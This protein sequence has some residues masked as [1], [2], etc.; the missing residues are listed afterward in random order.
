MARAMA[1]NRAYL[2]SAD[3]KGREHAR[4]CFRRGRGR[5][6]R[7]G[8]ALAPRGGAL[9]RWRSEAE[10]GLSPAEAWG[11]AVRPISACF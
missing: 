9:A 11:R 6:A 5:A 3:C 2:P 1:D 4:R 7:V 10:P 8:A